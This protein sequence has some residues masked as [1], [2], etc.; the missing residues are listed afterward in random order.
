VHA[1]FLLP[2]G[3]QHFELGVIAGTIAAVGLLCALL[4][5]WRGPWRVEAAD[6]R[7]R[8]AAL[9][10]VTPLVSEYPQLHD[11]TILALA[12]ALLV[13]DAVRRGLDGS[14]TRARLALAALWVSCLIAPA[15]VTRVAPVALAPIAAL[16]LGWTI[17]G[18]LRRR[19]VPAA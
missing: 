17:L 4:W 1:I 5:L 12:G 6:F 10:V 11:L 14:M 19:G 18:E 13:E 8:L 16:L 15:V 9:A 3:P 7:L 2:L